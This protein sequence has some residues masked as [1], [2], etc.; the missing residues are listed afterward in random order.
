VCFFSGVC[1]PFVCLGLF[2]LES[3]CFRDFRGLGSC[4]VDTAGGECIGGQS[5]VVTGWGRIGRGGELG[6]KSG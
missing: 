5:N 2:L 6:R 4:T 1:G 3:A